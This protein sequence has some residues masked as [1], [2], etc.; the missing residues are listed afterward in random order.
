MPWKK[1]D[2]SQLP[3]MCPFAREGLLFIFFF[4]PLFFF[5]KIIN[6]LTSSE[7]FGC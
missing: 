1:V 6:D 5:L 4:F 3:A 7:N 2:E